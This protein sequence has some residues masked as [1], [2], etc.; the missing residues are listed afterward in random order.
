MQGHLHPRPHL[1]HPLQQQLT[2]L[3]SAALPPTGGNGGGDDSTTS[4]GSKGDDSSR[5]AALDSL[6][7]NIIYPP[8]SLL[9]V[10][11][12][13]FLSQGLSQLLSDK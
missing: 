10:H 13:S 6:H 12:I 8:N 5:L 9:L 7:C 4:E 11:S 3:L 2:A 1:H